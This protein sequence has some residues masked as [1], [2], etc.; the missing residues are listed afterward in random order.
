MTQLVL[1]DLDGTLLSGLSSENEF[2]FYLLRKGY[3]GLKQVCCFVGF[4]F[5]WFYRYHLYVWIKNKAYL[6]GLSVPTIQQLGRDF[7][8]KNLIKKIKPQIRQFVNQHLQHGDIVVL[9]SG[10]HDFIAKPIAQ[11]LEIPY[12]E[13]TQCAIQNQVFTSAPPIQHPFREGK[14]EIAKKLSSQFNIPLS[15]CV[16]YGN[17]INDALLLKQVG[18]PVA[19]HPDRQLLRLAQKN[20]W[21]II[22]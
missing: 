12:V 17:S 18:Y 9:V 22:Q 21:K 3:I 7:T 10:S 14:V 15:Q 13:A 1:F 8:A 6:T 16:A 4:L 2:G 19:V 20:Q 5:K 11:N